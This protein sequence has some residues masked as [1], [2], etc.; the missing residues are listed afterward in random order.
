[1][2]DKLK[3]RLVG[4]LVLLALGVLLWPLLVGPGQQRNVVIESNI[5]ERPDFEPFEIPAPQKPESL[6]DPG[7]WQEE[8][9]ETL[10]ELEPTPEPQEKEQNIQTSLDASGLP[11]GWMIQVGS[12]GQVENAEKL[13]SRL[14]DSGYKTFI[15]PAVGD[16]K[17]T[18]VYVGPMVDESAASSAAREI[19][20]QFK[21][22]PKVSKFLP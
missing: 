3:Q 15:R 21:L 14:R 1:M 8:V 10:V 16:F 13:S 18:R 19:K 12:F 5:P 6:P 20:K 9:E 11:Q 2:N 4:A 17:L 7:E 22:V